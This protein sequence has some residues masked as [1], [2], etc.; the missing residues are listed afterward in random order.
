MSRITL[1]TNSL[2]HGGSEKQAAFLGAGL[3]ERGWDVRVISM[4]GRDDYSDPELARRTTVI[5]K[6]GRGDMLNVVQ[7]TR[8]AIDPGAPVLCFNWYPHV[9]AALAVPGSLRVARFG[10]T[11][12]ADGVR[13]G[14]RLLARRAQRTAAAVVGCSWG[15]VKQAVAELGSPTTACACI[16]NAVYFAGD[17]PVGA[18]GPA[19]PRPY[20]LS[21]GRLSP[22]KDHATLIDAFGLVAQH[23]GHDLLIA[24]DGSGQAHV[25]RL[26]AESGVSDRIHMIGY[27]SDVPALLA[28]ADLLVHTSR[29]EGFGCVLVEAMAAGTPFVATDAPYG[30]RSIVDTVPGGVLVPVG[31][32]GAISDAVV[33]LLGDAEERERLA[34][35]GFEG[36]PR[37]FAPERILDAYEVLIRSM[38]RPPVVVRR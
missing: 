34:A 28:G 35:V 24:G 17:K 31:D 8:Q 32:V 10:G 9:V 30:P 21:V 22:E 5:G 3:L 23:V 11:P 18:G 15:V 12:S 36:V 38:S 19:W 29:W 20:L 33:R 7:G 25:S 2:G 13:G 6:R 26:V 27:R 14:R 4:L 16:P 1:I 37:F